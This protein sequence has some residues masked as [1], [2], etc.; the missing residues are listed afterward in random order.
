MLRRDKT[1]PF[2]GPW[3]HPALKSRLDLDFRG[4]GGYISLWAKTENLNSWANFP[5]DTLGAVW[6]VRTGMTLAEKQF[7]LYPRSV[8]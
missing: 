7:T 1:G 2:H 3:K 8:K 4:A 6:S 5:V